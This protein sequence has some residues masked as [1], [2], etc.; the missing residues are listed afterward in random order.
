MQHDP[1]MH[2]GSMSKKLASFEVALK[3][4]KQIAEGTM[5]FVFEKPDGLDLKL[6]SMSE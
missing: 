1:S 3:D 4:K 6:V 2:M 5:A